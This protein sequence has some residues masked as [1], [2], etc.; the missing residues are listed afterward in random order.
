MI[1]ITTLEDLLAE[2]VKI[3]G[4]NEDYVLLSKGSKMI[5]II[6]NFKLK[7]VVI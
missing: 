1:K 6:G 5:K 7:E 2:D 4:L 3:V